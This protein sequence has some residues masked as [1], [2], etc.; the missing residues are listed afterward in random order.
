MSAKQLAVQPRATTEI[1]H[2]ERI[3]TRQSRRNDLEQPARG[4]ILEL[5]A[6]IGVVERCEARI[7]LL[8]ELIRSSRRWRIVAQCH[9]NVLDLRVL[10]MSF[11]VALVRLARLGPAT[12]DMSELTEPTPHQRLV[13]SQLGGVRLTDEGRE[14]S[15]ITTK[16]IRELGKSAG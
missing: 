7:E 4:P 11:E 1:Q 16:A 9:Q 14:Y 5:V 15:V 13:G 10:G 12:D 6:H 2:V 3:A 8:D